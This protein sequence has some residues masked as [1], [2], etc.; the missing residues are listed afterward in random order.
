MPECILPLGCAHDPPCAFVC[1]VSQDQATER[2]DGAEE[3]SEAEA[4]GDAEGDQSGQKP[5]GE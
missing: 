1:L 3:S 2:A 5:E 4:S